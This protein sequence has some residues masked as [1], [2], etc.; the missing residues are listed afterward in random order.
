MNIYHLIDHTPRIQGFYL[1]KK[2]YFIPLFNG[3]EIQ[4]G[5]GVTLRPFNKMLLCGTRR[6]L[7]FSKVSVTRAE[8]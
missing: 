7:Y 5:G 4:D 3:S 2:L 6:V 8:V 1:L